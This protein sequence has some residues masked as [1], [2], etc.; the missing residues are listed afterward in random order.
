MTQLIQS[1]PFINILVKVRPNP[2]ANG[3]AVETAPAVPYICQPDT[4]INFQIFDTGTNHIVFDSSNP[5]TVVPE[6]NGQLSS[7][8]VSLSGKQLAFVD[9]NSIKMKMNITLNFIDEKGVQFS[10]D[11]EI[12]NEPD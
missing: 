7:P 1:T 4:I 11:P 3:Y 6:D 10:H 12:E 8:S 5:M 2:D 9:L